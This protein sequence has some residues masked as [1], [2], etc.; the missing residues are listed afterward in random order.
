[1]KDFIK[2]PLNYTGNKYKL[3]R[4]LLPLFPRNITTFVDAFTGSGTVVA[5]VDA[6]NKVAIEYNT[7]L[8]DILKGYLV[9]CL[10]LHQIVYFFYLV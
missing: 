10:I 8:A 2:S 1:M 9:F 5:N 7:K 3:L 6:R 4:Q